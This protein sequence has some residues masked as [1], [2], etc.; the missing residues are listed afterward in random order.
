M[1][2]NILVISGINTNKYFVCTGEG[3]R[4]NYNINYKA[5]NLYIK[6][7]KYKEYF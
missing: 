3:K 5:L 7:K 2:W 6:I 1:N 4:N